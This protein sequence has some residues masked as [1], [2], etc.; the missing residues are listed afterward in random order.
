MEKGRYIEA[1]RS[2]RV[3]IAQQLGI[4]ESTMNMAMAYNRSGEKSLEARRLVLE[5]E[6]A[7]IMNYLPECETIHDAEGVMTQVFT[8]GYVIKVYKDTGLVEVYNNHGVLKS[9]DYNPNITEFS[10]LQF[11]VENSQPE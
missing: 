8:N 10:S 3:R 11:K 5:S 6:E 2:V 4:S 1:P 9:Q 7:V